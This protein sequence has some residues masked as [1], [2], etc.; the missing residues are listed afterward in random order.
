M[1]AAYA[2][3]FDPPTLGHEEIIQK[4]AALFDELLILVSPNSAKTGLFSAE[5]RKAWLEQIAKDHPNVCVEICAGL[6]VEAARAGKADVLL[7]SMRSMADY[8][9]EANNAWKIGRAHV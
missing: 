6:T 8:E 1:K 5:Q 3:S 4:A 7:R 9:G 2:G